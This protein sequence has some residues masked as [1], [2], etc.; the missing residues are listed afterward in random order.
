MPKQPMV[1]SQLPWQPKTPTHSSP[2]P[3]HST[4]CVTLITQ[5]QLSFHNHDTPSPQTM[6]SSHPPPLEKPSID[7]NHKFIKTIV[8]LHQNPSLHCKTQ[9]EHG[10]NYIH[11]FTSKH[12]QGAQPEVFSKERLCWGGVWWRNHL[13]NDR[14]G[15]E[16]ETWSSCQRE[17]E[18]T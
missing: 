11:V 12:K 7:Y 9:I 15:S 17:R 14:L 13:R 2:N 16:W 18:G 5:N 3:I 1:Q 8:M 6:T 4:P 10:H